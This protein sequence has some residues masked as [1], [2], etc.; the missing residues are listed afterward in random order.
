MDSIKNNTMRI[1]CLTASVFLVLTNKSSTLP[2]LLSY[3][4]LLLFRQ[5]NQTKSHLYVQAAAAFAHRWCLCFEIEPYKIDISLEGKC[6][7]V[8]IHLFYS[9]STK[10]AFNFQFCVPPVCCRSCAVKTDDAAPD[11]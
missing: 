1:V 11:H 10:S 8:Y 4:L 3:Y 9:K 2:S 7:L 5:V 6:Y